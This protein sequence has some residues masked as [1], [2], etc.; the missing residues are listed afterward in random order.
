MHINK[1]DQMV[2]INITALPRGFHRFCSQRPQHLQ[3]HIEAS[4]GLRPLQ[5]IKAKEHNV[6]KDTSGLPLPDILDTITFHHGHVAIILA[7]CCSYT[8]I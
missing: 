8:L 7:F 5:F 1:S 3:N 4:A 2:S 6:W